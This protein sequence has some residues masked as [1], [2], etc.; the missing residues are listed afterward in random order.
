MTD[1]TSDVPSVTSSAASVPIDARKRAEQ[2]RD[3]L[4]QLIREGH[5]RE[6][7]KLPTEPQL[8]AMFG[9]GRSS[10]RE[11]VQSLIGL[12]V[13]EM[14]PGRGAYV[15]RLS[16]NDLVRM[17]DGAVRLEY[18]AALQL[19]EV[20]AMIEITAARLAAS[21]RDDAD[22]ATL[23]EAILRYKIAG[24]AA[25]PDRLI[26]ADLA[27]H[28]AI[29]V[30]THNDVLVTVL[31]SIRGLLREHRRQYGVAGEVEA[32][33]VVIDEHEAIYAAIAAEDPARAAKR[34]Q[35][36]MRIIWRQIEAL[37][38]RDGDSTLASQAYLP[39]YDD[40]GEPPG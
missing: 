24:Q 14:R 35:E 4:V 31:Q 15:R 6:G 32:R 20:R 40:D 11:A 3:R 37:A 22:L 39:M 25:D 13:I 10:I 38:I 28:E 30:A 23:R 27:F 7:E 1:R 21:R 33:A 12:G 5:L 16:L 9:V 26:D 18:G 36:H 29:V 17:V 8:S 19:H 2:V 34:M